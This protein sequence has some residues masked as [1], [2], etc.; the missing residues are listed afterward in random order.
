MKKDRTGLYMFI[1]CVSV[2]AIVLVISLVM[3]NNDN[4]SSSDFANSEIFSAGNGYGS[5]IEIDVDLFKEIRDS[6]K[7]SVIYVGRPT[8][9]FCLQYEPIL[10][11]VTEDTGLDIFYV[12][13]DEWDSNDMNNILRP[14]MNNFTGV[15]RTFIMYEGNEVVYRVGVMQ[16]NELLRFLQD[17]NIIRE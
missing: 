17:N 12:N 15:P 6:D 3:H 11:N 14:I 8:C 1:A 13:I 5:L 9:P 10:H 16:E 7:V 4:N 2:I